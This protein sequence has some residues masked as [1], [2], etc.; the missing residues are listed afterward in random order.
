MEANT[1]SWIITGIVAAIVLLLGWVLL[2]H[3]APV[4]PAVG[5]VSIPSDTQTATEAPTRVTDTSMKPS[6]VP[7][8]PNTTAVGETISVSD[9]PA[10]SF[11]SVESARLHRPSWIAIKDTKGW[12][13]GA[14][15][16]SSSVETVT[17]PLLRNT[18]AGETY[19]AV[20]YIDNGDKRFDMHADT[21]VASVDGG[22]VASTF[23]ATHGD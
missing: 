6:P 13:L 17:V 19:Q 12:V 9:Q 8:I 23:T 5:D 18:L 10:G 11:V 4:S 2:G 1:R 14:A 7:T 21:L 22:P 15:W 3:R 16:F 20:I